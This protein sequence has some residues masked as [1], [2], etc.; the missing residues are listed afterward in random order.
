MPQICAINVTWRA[1]SGEEKV[2]DPYENDKQ[3]IIIL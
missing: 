2:M 3:L 1:F